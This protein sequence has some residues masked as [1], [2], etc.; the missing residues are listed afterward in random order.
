[1]FMIVGLLFLFGLP[2]SFGIGVTI[3]YFVWLAFRKQQIK[4]AK[5]YVLRGG[6]LYIV[7]QP[8][9][10]IFIAFLPIRKIDKLLGYSIPLEGFSLC[11]MIFAVL[12]AFTFTTSVLYLMAKRQT[13]N[14]QS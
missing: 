12:F 8:I 6:I 3:G 5:F 10:F 11:E 14:Q 9:S 13:G 4:K 2:I 1:M 7:S